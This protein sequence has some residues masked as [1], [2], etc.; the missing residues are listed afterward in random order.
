MFERFTEPG[1]KVV[2]TAQEES[3]K[4]GNNFV[5]TE[6]IL[7]GLIAETSGIGGRILRK[8]GVTLRLA[9]DEIKRL[10]GRGSGFVAVE[11]PFT[12]RARRVLENAID[13]SKNLGFPYVGPEHILLGILME[14][15]GIAIT[16][17]RKVLQDVNPDV[18]FDT[19][20]KRTLRE[21]GE[22]FDEEFGRGKPRDK[23]SP[24][25]GTSNLAPSVPDFTKDPNSLE[26]YDPAMIHP[27]F[28]PNSPLLLSP[29]L[30]EY[31]Q[32]I[33]QMAFAGEIDPV[34]GRDIEVER[35]LQVLSRRRKNNPILLGEPGVG[36]TAVA[37][38]LAL[39]IIGG[40]VP[41]P[42][43]GKNII[44]LDLGL[45][46]AGSR[47]RGDFEKRLKR[48]ISD[49]QL[50]KCYILVVDEVHTLVGA[51][52]AEGSLDAANILKPAL[53][54]GEFQCIG[55]TTL[56]EYRKYIEPDA[57]LAR[58]FQN[59]FV[60]EPSVD[61]TISI[62]VGIRDK[63]EAHHSV[64]ITQNALEEAAVLTS[65]YINDR[66]LPDKAID[67]IDEAC[68]R[69]RLGYELIP[70]ICN[71]FEDQL[72]YLC[73]EKDAAYAD[74]DWS[75]ALD[76]LRS[77]IKF[78]QQFLN[79]TYDLIGKLREQRKIWV[80]RGL[81]QRYQFILK[82]TGPMLKE[83]EI[84]LAIYDNEQ[85]IQKLNTG[86]NN[87]KSGSDSLSQEDSGNLPTPQD[88]KELENKLL[89]Y[90]AEI[91]NQPMESYVDKPPLDE[92]G[93][94]MTYDESI[95]KGL[96]DR[97]FD[98]MNPFAEQ[99][100]DN[101]QKEINNMEDLDRVEELQKK[102]DE[103]GS[104]LPDLRKTKKETSNS[105]SDELYQKNNSANRIEDIL[106]GVEKSITPNKNSNGIEKIG[107]EKTQT[108]SAKKTSSKRKKKKSNTLDW[109]F[110]ERE[111]SNLN[112]TSIPL[113]Q[114]AKNSVYASLFR[115]KLSESKIL[116]FD[117]QNIPDV[118]SETI[119]KKLFMEL[120]SP[121]DTPTPSENSSDL[122]ST[123]KVSTVEF[124]YDE[125][126]LST[127][128]Y[129][130]NHPP[131]G[132]TGKMRWQLENEVYVEIDVATQKLWGL[133]S[134][135]VWNKFL[136]KQ[137]LENEENKKLAA[138]KR[139]TAKQKEIEEENSKLS[140]LLDTKLGKSQIS[141]VM[142]SLQEREK[143]CIKLNKI[144]FTRPF[145]ELLNLCHETLLD[146]VG[147]ALIERFGYG[148]S[149]KFLSDEPKTNE[150]KQKIEIDKKLELSDIAKKFIAKNPDWLTMDPKDY[151]EDYL[152]EL[153]KLE[154]RGNQAADLIIAEFYAEQDKISDSETNQPS[155]LI[156]QVVAANYDAEIDKVEKT[157]ETTSQEL[158]EMSQ[159][160]L[161]NYDTNYVPWVFS[162]DI[163][164]VISEWTGIPVSKV[165]KDETA[166]L[167]AI[168]QELQK[169][170][171]GQPE[172]VEAIAKALRRGRVGLLDLSRPIASFFFSGPTGVGKTEVTKALAA[173]YFGGEGDM[174][175]FDM[176]EFM[177][178][179][180]VSKLIGSP[181][182]YVG[183][184]EGGQLTEAVRR[185]PYVVVLFDEVEKAHPDVFN[186]L[187]QVLED[188][189]LS[190]SQGRVV[191]FKNT[192]I[193]MTSNL[194]AKAIQNPEKFSSN[195][196]GTQNTNQDKINFD[197]IALDDDNPEKT[198]DE[199]IKDLVME[200]LKG[201]FRP[202]F[203]NRIDEIVVFR[204]LTKPDIR[205]IASIMLNSL[206]ERLLSK[207]Y[208]LLLSDSV[209][210]QILEEGF[211]PEYGARPLR[212]VITNRLEDTLA[213]VILEKNISP[214]SSIWVNYKNGK[215]AIYHKNFTNTED[216]GEAFFKKQQDDENIEKIE[217][218]SDSTENDS[219]TV[220]PVSIESV[221]DRQTIE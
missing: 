59:V 95:P 41:M 133:L 16:A 107:S 3:R 13:E 179:H 65:R 191:D 164:G 78:V 119:Q 56:A 92:Q 73:R 182:G 105:T 217:N 206:K 79:F 161:Q 68:S 43:Q 189:R 195:K 141:Y 130:K 25:S 183:Y 116:L 85:L 89:E 201:F 168:E 88:Q 159:R 214:G 120:L 121:F 81:Q 27:Y 90:R 50:T 61:D 54:R 176:S 23:T 149:E 167:L 26:E 202:E 126:F 55:A 72:A 14:D 163:A 2:V 221:T 139:K 200:E 170:V 60:K 138:R 48:V 108:E 219:I 205:D 106:A 33:T 132:G 67:A 140:K 143:R 20:R 75:T 1:I 177:E 71:E 37:E 187:L 76:V 31:T 158:N 115:K 146:R 171:I 83:W 4:I 84:V 9:R 94:P 24:T 10:V 29:V 17:L 11:I 150:Q 175:R 35:V 152:E 109:Q 144:N 190:D 39:Q 70:N 91:Q 97:E 49:I 181:P 165:S 74:K 122:K 100:L 211:D 199:V 209:I 153:E 210:E 86:K 194:G 36:K 21:M 114:F 173:S 42:L 193:V 160:V 166:K 66:F 22:E 180:T 6:Q 142:Y 58:R 215:F 169:R 44:T 5:G 8:Y 185:K 178:R 145:E 147:N 220:D 157:N 134:F 154:E 123:K 77:E 7:L 162:S 12:P 80:I 212:R 124:K 87:L 32:N 129:N 101:I 18:T 102:F 15:S 218:E 51:G 46:I 203:L 63:Y 82:G 103:R 135:I 197:D 99:E 52:A 151:L 104:T 196:G 128:E 28:D 131:L 148:Y 19:I 112:N 125:W 208:N 34:I 188:G 93:N 57:A 69:V 204:K 62:L 40:Q 213:G 156:N 96:G 111:L 45:L 30:D 38:G 118:V 64:Q 137:N 192:I 127:A 53:A 207:A 47:Y 174:V 113:V 155:E 117:E 136:L 216:L 98:E 110:D 172:A 184:T 198:E 186:L